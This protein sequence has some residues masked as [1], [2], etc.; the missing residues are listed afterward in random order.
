MLR[1]HGKTRQSSEPDAEAPPAPRILVVDD[2]AFTRYNL[3]TLLAS[4]G[5]EVVD[6]PD[7]E[8]AV[9]IYA[10]SQP[11]AVLLDITMPGMDGLDTLRSIRQ[12]NANARVAMVTGLGQQTIVLEAIKSGAADFIVKP[13]QPDRV[14]V[15]L[16]KLLA[17]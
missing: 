14:L 2:S 9:E 13:F 10:A 12:L 11:D 5:Y 16:Q 17:T 1:L 7:G 6:A 8:T 4:N 3:R 15:A